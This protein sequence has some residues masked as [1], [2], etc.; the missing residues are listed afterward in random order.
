M[1]T[2]VWQ[3]IPMVHPFAPFRIKFAGGVLLQFRVTCNGGAPHDDISQYTA[4][5]IIAGSGERVNFKC[6]T[7]PDRHVWWWAEPLL[8]QW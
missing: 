5:S 6:A 8:S 3:K 2:Y 7:P 1:E 4:K